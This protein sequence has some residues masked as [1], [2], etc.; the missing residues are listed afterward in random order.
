MN[1]SKIALDVTID[2]YQIGE[3]YQRS[4]RPCLFDPI[5]EILVVITPEEIVRQKFVHYLINEL[6]VPKD[7]IELEVPLTHFK[8]RARDRADIV[9][10]G[11]DKEDKKYPLM[12][13]ECKA[14]IIPLTDDVWDQ[15]LRYEKVIN[16]GVLVITNGEIIYSAAFNQEDGSYRP[17]EKILNY[18]ELLEKR[19]YPFYKDDGWKWTRP[20]FKDLLL[21][22]IIEDFKSFGNIGEDT[23]E[24]LYPFIIDLAGFFL[25]QTLH[26]SPYQWEDLKVVDD[27]IRFT[28]FGNAAG[29]TWT[30][31][32]HYFMIEDE[33]GENQIVSISIQASMR[34]VNDPRFGNRKGVTTLIVAIDDFEK[35]HNSLQLCMDKYTIYEN[36][37][38]FI[39][40][41]GTLTVGNK[42]SAKKSEVIQFIKDREPS[43]INKQGRVLLGTFDSKRPISFDQAETRSF[44]RNII[45]Y[46]LVRD[47]FRR[48]KSGN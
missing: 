47:E 18:K 13:V 25:D 26:F 40:H 37:Q 20:D 3:S 11:K 12:I 23:P 16:A 9:V 42:G 21:P 36:N 1:L 34:F 14:A 22:Q 30:N 29:G 48:Y 7:M 5:R 19:D 41:D 6:N 24:H 35:R 33:A 8:K 32:Y 28:T 45:R 44:I 31:D 2:N 17:L 46:A 15:V 10:F 38:Y 4:G 39:W 27:G 43:L